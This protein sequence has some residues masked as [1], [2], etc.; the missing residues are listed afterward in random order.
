MATSMGHLDQE[1]Q[2]FQST[3]SLKEILNKPLH[4]DIKD[5]YFPDESNV[6]KTNDVV[7]KIVT[8]SETRK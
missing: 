5:D 8:F 1:C 7:A 6:K 4:P 2:W 3:K